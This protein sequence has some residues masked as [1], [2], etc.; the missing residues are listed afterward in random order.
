MSVT[1]VFAERIGCHVILGESVEQ[2][3]GDGFAYLVPKDVS[4][5][6]V[7]EK[8][9]FALVNGSHG[10]LLTSENP[11]FRS[12]LSGGLRVNLL[13]I[14]SVGESVKGT[15]ER[16]GIVTT[17]ASL[18]A[19][20]V[21]ELSRSLR[22][23]LPIPRGAQFYG[24]DHDMPYPVEVLQV[25]SAQGI[26]RKY[27]FVLELESGFGGR[28]RWAARQFGCQ[29]LGVEPDEKAAQVAQALGKY[30]GELSQAVFCRGGLEALPFRSG[31]FTHVWWLWPRSAV[32]PR[33]CLREA[34]R[35]LRD[36]GYFAWVVGWEGEASRQAERQLREVGF[37]ITEKRRLEVGRPNPWFA[38]AR[39]R[40]EQ[41]IREVPELHNVW[42]GRVQEWVEGAC[43]AL[44]FARRGTKHEQ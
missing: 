11:V 3:F 29:V 24:L 17:T 33:K 28:A 43:L 6:E 42:S 13:T 20:K 40:F 27:E 21:F 30:A 10:N 1:A 38:L 4:D 7:F 14:A 2:T 16:S 31:A 32:E 5:S 12:P 8:I 18:L 44:L 15:H 9:A 37:V 35:V 41:A 22:A 26:F 36:G 39:R 23:E 34:H 25:L 19:R